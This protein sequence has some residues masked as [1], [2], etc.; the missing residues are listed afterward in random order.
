MASDAELRS[1]IA[2]QRRE[3]A[4][5][6]D[7]LSEA[8]VAHPSLCSGWTVKDVAVHL[9]I[10]LHVGL[11]RFAVA[12][13]G[14]RGNFDRAMTKLVAKESG[15]SKVDVARELRDQAEHP[16]TPPGG[17]G[18]TAP[19]VDL[20]VHTQDICRPLGLARRLIPDRT[21]A[22]LVGLGSK[23]FDKVLKRERFTGLRFEATDLD[24]TSGAGQTVI[25]PGEALL[26]T[27]LDRPIALD[28]L[29]GDG[30]ALL[31]TRLAS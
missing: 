30:V 22:A 9:T 5:L 3:A 16:F 25:G 10:P 1:M 2:A 6:L 24:F 23:K 27:L 14:A 8:Q 18:P 19:L 26:L 28:D 31:R 7:G 11:G 29:S 15:R 20:L 4:D 13:L 21:Q 12:L 17:Y